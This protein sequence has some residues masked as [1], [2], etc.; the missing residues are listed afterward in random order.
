MIKIF[1]PTYYAIADGDT[2]IEGESEQLAWTW[3]NPEVGDRLSLG[4]A[5]LWEVSVV[6]KYKR[7]DGTALY[8]AYMALVDTEVKPRAEWFDVERLLT[9]PT[10]CLNLY[11]ERDGGLHQS[12]RNF[13]GQVPATGHFLSQ[14]DAETRKT[15][16]S[17][18]WTTG[19]TT[20][21]SADPSAT[22]D[23]IHL[24]RVE[25]YLETD[26]DASALEPQKAAIA[27]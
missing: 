1:S 15:S 7:E 9:D 23:R 27:V 10:T 25:E 4:L 5:R 11:A 12:S 20:F 17:T 18:F 6:H 2:R 3:N 22:F 8:V 24:A 16:A 14:F 13:L 21:T 26:D 19:F